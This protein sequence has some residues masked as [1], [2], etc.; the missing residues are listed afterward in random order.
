MKRVR[1]SRAK[2]HEVMKRVSTACQLIEDGAGI[3]NACA[4]A[5]IS[6]PTFKKYRTQKPA[7]QVSQEVCSN[8]DMIGL[9]SRVLKNQLNQEDMATIIT[10]VIKRF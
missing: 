1:K 10:S 7:A 6:Y 2:K 9:I 3:G 4:A 8:F 5:G